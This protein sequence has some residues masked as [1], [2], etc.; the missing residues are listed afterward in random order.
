M[1][2]TTDLYP[3]FL[4]LLSIQIFKLLFF[5]TCEKL[6]NVWLL[7]KDRR[8][9]D[10][11]EIYKFLLFTHKSLLDSDDDFTQVVEMSV[12]VTDNSPFQDYTTQSTKTIT[13]QCL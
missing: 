13:A 7:A 5:F 2:Y 8:G 9:F 10:E 4:G 12:I 11:A 3:N 1:G 6:P